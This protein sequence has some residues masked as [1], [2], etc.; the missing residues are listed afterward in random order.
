MATKLQ[1]QAWNSAKPES[2]LL[3]LQKQYTIEATKD[4]IK[5]TPKPNERLCYQ[6]KRYKPKLLELLGAGKTTRQRIDD[7]WRSMGVDPDTYQAQERQA[8]QSEHDYKCTASFPVPQESPPVEAPWPSPVIDRVKQDYCQHLGAAHYRI[9]TDHGAVVK[10]LC[11]GCGHNMKGPRRF[12][13]ARKRSTVPWWPAD[14]QVVPDPD[15]ETD[16]LVEWWNTVEGS[17]VDGM[18]ISQAITIT[19]AGTFKRTMT[20]SIAL[21]KFGD[22]DHG[23]KAQLQAIKKHMEVA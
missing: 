6:I 23:L 20:E 18:V 1:E 3:E 5:V 2:V 10:Y 7:A 13:E 8:I 14:A 15:A 16:A 12:T 17:I 11:P 19:N 9:K 4:T 22:P 21:W